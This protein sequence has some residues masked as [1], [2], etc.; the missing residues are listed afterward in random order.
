MVP[1]RCLVSKNHCASAPRL[2]LARDRMHPQRPGS[3]RLAM[4]DSLADGIPRLLS[5]NLL[6]FT[7]RADLHRPLEG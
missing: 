6:A 1:L 2:P 7:G 5:G 4:G 3:E